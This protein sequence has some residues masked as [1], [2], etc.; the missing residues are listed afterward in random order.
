MCLDLFDIFNH[1]FDAM[2]FG[3][4]GRDELDVVTDGDE[5]RDNF[6]KHKSFR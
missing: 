6:D 1:R 5:E 2:V 3:H 4:Q